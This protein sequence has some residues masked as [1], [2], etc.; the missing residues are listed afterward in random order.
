[1]YWPS[2]FHIPQISHRLE[3][4]LDATCFGYPRLQ[5]SLERKPV[6]YVFYVLLNLFTGIFETMKKLLSHFV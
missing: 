6:D 2:C 5:E 1:M 4:P 3:S